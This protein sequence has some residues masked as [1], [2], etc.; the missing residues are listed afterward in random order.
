M[1]NKQ[2]GVSKYDFVSTQDM[3]VIL[4]VTDANERHGLRNMII[5]FIIPHG[6]ACC[7]V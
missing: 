4:L 3:T 1:P 2:L 5:Q 7:G 6:V